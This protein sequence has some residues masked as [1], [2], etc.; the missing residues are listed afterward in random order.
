MRVSLIGFEGSPAK[1][2][3]ERPVEDYPIPGTKYQTYFL[4]ASAGSMSPSKF[5]TESKTSYEAHHLTDCSDFVVHFDEYTELAGYPIAK[6]FMSCDE[7]DDMDVVVQLR[8][9]GKDGKPLV[10]LNYK[11][12]VPE[13]EVANTNIAKFL[14]PD[15]MLRASHRVSKEVVDGRLHYAHDHAEKVPRGEIVALEIPIWPVGMAFEAGE[16]IMLR[17]AGHELRLPEVE[18]LRADEPFDENVGNHQIHTGG[19]FDSSLVLP[20]IARG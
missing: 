1:T 6:L 16:G 8:K 9:V 4:D 10:S 14:G 18:M 15:G 11:C 13:A 5:E 20:V 17:V 7:H 19:N 2:I 12:P 3:V